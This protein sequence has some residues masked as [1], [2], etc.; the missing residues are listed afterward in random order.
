MNI[1]IITTGLGMGGAEN[2]ICS[3]ADKLANNHNVVIINLS[4][5]SSIQITPKNKNIT[6]HSYEIKKNFLSLILTPIKI[7][8][9]INEYSPHIIH[10]H[11]FHANIL[12]RILKLFIRK[13]I[14]VCTA[15]S[16]N[17]GGKLRMFLYRITD[18]LATISTNVSQ[19]AVDSFIAKKATKKGRMIPFYNGID[20]STFCYKPIVRNIKRK[21]INIS[22]KTSIILAVG[23]LTPAKDY[24]NLLYAFS[25][26]NTPTQPKLVIIGDGEE[27]NSLLQLA[28]N[29]NISS[30]IIWLGQ[31]YDVSEWMSAC[32][33]FVLSSA[34]EGFGLVVA[35]AMACER[36]VIGTNSGGVSEVINKH[37]FIIPPENSVALTA[38]IEKC[39]SLTNEEKYTIGLNARNY[40]FDNFSLEKISQQW[41]DLYTYLIKKNEK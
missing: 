15:H 22:E 10:S 38:A 28:D 35:E 1:L 23:R 2:Q 25:R 37:G 40:I 14:L 33:V 4:S 12:S 32:D 41:I 8:K 16:K 29:L 9:Y 19:E 11:M 7:I 13:T 21:E 36:P 6:I 20:M 34:W 30:N 5:Q 24:S 17:E 39:L 18:S 26:I 31:R 3:L 27:K